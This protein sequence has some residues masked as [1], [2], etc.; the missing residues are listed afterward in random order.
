MKRTFIALAIVLAGCAP[1][2]AHEFTVGELMVEHPWARPSLGASP[3]GAAYLIVK[4]NGKEADRLLSVSGDVAGR[5][6]LHATLMDGDVMRMRPVK[7]GVEIPP[8]QSV[9]IVPGGLHIMLMGLAAPLKEGD[10]FP[11]SLQFERAGSVD[12]S[13]HVETKP[14]KSAPPMRE[15]HHE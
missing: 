5:V 4:N 8:G 10:S 1:S 3:N 11:L 13:V 9:E 2:W 12:V 15:H 6:E 7:D 14:E